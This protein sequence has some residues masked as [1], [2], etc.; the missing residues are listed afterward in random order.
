MQTILYPQI[1]FSD[2]FHDL[3]TRT[4]ADRFSQVLEGVT[5]AAHTLI[6]RKPCLLLVADDTNA[7]G[8]HIVYA[9]IDTLRDE[10]RV[11]IPPEP[12][13][14]NGEAGVKGGR[15]PTVCHAVELVAA[16]CKT[17]GIDFPKLRFSKDDDT[18]V[19]A[20][21]QKLVEGSTII[22]P[23]TINPPNTNV[24]ICH[25]QVPRIDPQRLLLGWYEVI[26]HDKN[27]VSDPIRHTILVM[28]KSQSDEHKND[29]FT[30]DQPPVKT[31]VMTETLPK[32]T[33]D[34]RSRFRPLHM[35]RVSRW[36][37][38]SNLNGCPIPAI[39]LIGKRYS[40]VLK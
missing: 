31:I 19:V 25:T 6:A 7:G 10:V 30:Q 18:A 40:I 27:L 39:E 14:T 38:L 9:L 12:D 8:K 37:K 34:D 15:F 32:D 17:A 20:D 13:V 36:G 35:N 26:K 23:L 5:K 24:F 1:S 22:M 33:I 29:Y 21:W 11:L 28:P 4:E 16:C 2:L 3:E